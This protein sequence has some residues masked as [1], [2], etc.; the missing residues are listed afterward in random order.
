MRK[1]ELNKRWVF[2]RLSQNKTW[3]VL[4]YK[5][6]FLAR[7]LAPLISE[8]EFHIHR[9]GAFKLNNIKRVFAVQ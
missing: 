6:S 8:L 5:Y 4:Q 3:A 1:S 7:I 9:L 2:T